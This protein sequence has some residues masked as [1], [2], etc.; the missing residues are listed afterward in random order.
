MTYPSHFATGANVPR[1]AFAASNREQ[2]HDL[3]GL[4]PFICAICRRYQTQ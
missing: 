3:Q 4:P 1:G 2:Q